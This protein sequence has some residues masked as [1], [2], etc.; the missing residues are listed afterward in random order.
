MYQQVAVN[1]QELVKRR[2]DIRHHNKQSRSPDFCM[3]FILFALRGALIAMPCS[4]LVA[5]SGTG[6]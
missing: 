2:Y 3:A 1:L 5:C 6:L 4:K